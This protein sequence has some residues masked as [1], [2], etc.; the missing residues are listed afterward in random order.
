MAEAW[1]VVR[2]R[3][4][5]RVFYKFTEQDVASSTDLMGDG[6]LDSLSVFVILA[7][8]DEELGSEVAVERARIPDTASLDAI[9][10]LY[11]RLL[12]ER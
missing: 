6:Y 10:A 5:K 11:V 7:T 4:L 8:L 2:E 1:E 12:A 3:V 9:G